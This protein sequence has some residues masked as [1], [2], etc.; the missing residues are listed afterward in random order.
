MSV[1]C[2]SLPSPLR[3]KSASADSART[4]RVRDHR[5]DFWRGLC[6]VD[7]VLV[8]L[9][10]ENVY[11]GAGLSRFIGEYS[12]FAAGGFVFVAGLSVGAIYLPRSIDPA[13]RRA[14]YLSLW[15]RAAILLIVQWASTV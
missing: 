5:L 2:F 6:L 7:M 12:R 8:H 9:V 10:Y 3:A 13:R 4:P 14:T 1:S 11:F 15:R